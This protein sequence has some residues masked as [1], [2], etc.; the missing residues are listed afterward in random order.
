VLAL[1]APAASALT[2]GPAH[3]QTVSATVSGTVTGL[4]VNNDVGDIVVVPGSVTRIV[5]AEQYSFNAPTVRHSLRNGLLTVVARCPRTAGPLDVGL[6]DCAADLVITAP[7]DVTVDAFDSVGD[8]RT[9]DL[10]GV[11]SLRDDVGDV[12]VTRVTAFSVRAISSDGVLRLTAER[13]PSLDLRSDTGDIHADLATMPRSVVARSSDG[14]VYLTLP[15][16]AYAVD[17]HTDDG[18]THVHGI[19]EQSD[20]PRTVSART[21]EGD[22]RIVGR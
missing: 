7:R 17:T 6:N 22:I 21:A 16:G 5:A 12:A 1:A 3:H 19:T 13:T 11:E 15:A 8:I 10:R 18:T 14:D 20:A 2:V 4:S 9:R